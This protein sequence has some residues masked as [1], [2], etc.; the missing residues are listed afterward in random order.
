VKLGLPAPCQLASPPVVGV[1][2]GGVVVV[3][4]ITGLSCLSNNLQRIPEIAQEWWRSWSGGAGRV[5]GAWAADRD[6]SWLALTAL[7]ASRCLW[8]DPWSATYGFSWGLL[9]RAYSGLR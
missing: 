3:A 5:R 6:Q 4:G 9:S 1:V 2:G 7:P 8:L